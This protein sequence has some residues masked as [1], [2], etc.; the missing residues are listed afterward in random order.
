MKRKKKN[1]M[2]NHED[3]M[4]KFQNP[5]LFMK[6][7]Q[8]NKSEKVRFMPHQVLAINDLIHKKQ[9]IYAHQQDWEKLFPRFC[10][11]NFFWDRIKESIEN[12][13]RNKILWSL[14]LK[15]LILIQGKHFEIIFKVPLV[16]DSSLFI[17][18]LMI[19]KEYPFVKKHV[20]EL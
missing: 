19:L 9:I 5:Y 2:R 12:K 14:F 17:D 15:L 11:T 4:R 18:G 7:W 20:S 8:I 16:C 1:E 10:F 13:M 3:L 6:N